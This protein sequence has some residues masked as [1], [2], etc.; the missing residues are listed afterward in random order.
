[1]T[2]NDRIGAIIKGQHVMGDESGTRD[3]WAIQYVKKGM[4]KHQPSM[5]YVAIRHALKNY[6]VTV[7]QTADWKVRLLCP[8]TQ[9]EVIL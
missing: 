4:R 9:D 7:T 1:M 6:R 3:Y 5:R 2:L 8:E